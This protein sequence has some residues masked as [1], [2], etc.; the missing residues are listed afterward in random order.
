MVRYAEYTEQDFDKD[1]DRANQIGGRA[2]MELQ[3]GE[4]VVRFVPSN[5]PG[6][7]P[8]RSTGMHYVDAI[9]GLDKMV[10]FACPKK[11]L[12]QPCPVCDAGSQLMR[13]PNPIDRERGERIG[14][15]LTLYANVVDRSAPADDPNQGI[16]VLRFGKQILEQ[17][18]TI[19]RSTRTG[20]DFFD[21]GPNGFDIVITR[22][23]TEK[24]TKYKVIPDRQNSP[25]FEDTELAQYVIDN[26]YDLNT[27]VEAVVPDQVVAALQSAA[28]NVQLAGRAAPAARQLPQRASAPARQAPAAPSGQRSGS[29]LFEPTPPAA[30]AAQTIADADFTDEDDDFGPPPKA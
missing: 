23:G 30:S 19:R 3:Q 21:P 7:S 9:P 10:V 6:V 29:A 13:S 17:L 15:K 22:E 14:A 18:K 4:N 5:T 12:Q 24:S 28:G 20:G 1:V 25:L 11:E 27:F 8:I 26:A 2:I 16:R